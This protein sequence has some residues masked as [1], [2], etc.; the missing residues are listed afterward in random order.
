MFGGVSCAVSIQVVDFKIGRSNRIAEWTAHPT[1]P[2][3]HL[4]TTLA[5][6]SGG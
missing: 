5:C 4:D 1:S 2:N 3:S 6:P